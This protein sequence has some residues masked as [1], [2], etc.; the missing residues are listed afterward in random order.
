ME[1]NLIRGHRN[2]PPAAAAII[3]ASKSN[4][5]PPRLLFVTPKLR[6]S[7]TSMHKTR[8]ELRN[9]LPVIRRNAQNLPFFLSFYSS[10]IDNPSGKPCFLYLPVG[11][12]GRTRIDR[13]NFKRLTINVSRVIRTDRRIYSRN[14]LVYTSYRKL[15]DRPVSNYSNYFYPNYLTRPISRNE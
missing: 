8:G 3:E 7:K 14:E 15:I 5:T 4:T 6:R 11:K 13:G 10:S 9:F 2:R 1:R 12:F